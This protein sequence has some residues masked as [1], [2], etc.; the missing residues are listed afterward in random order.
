VKSAD[1][2]AAIRRR[3]PSAPQGRMVGQWTTL[4][5]L[6]G[7]DAVA[8][9]AWGKGER[10][11][12]EVKVSRS[13][14]RR[15]LLC[16]EKREPY[17]AHVH[18]LFLATPA[19]LL[20]DDE[21]AYKQP[22]DWT[23]DDYLRPACTNE[24]CWFNNARWASNRRARRFV[25]KPF[26]RRV[27]GHRARGRHDQPRQPCATTG[28]TVRD[29]RTT[30]RSRRAASSAAAPARPDRHASSGRRRRSGYRRTS[31]CSKC[32]SPATAASSE[33]RRDSNR[34]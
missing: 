17:K 34:R 26:S 13:D 32:T 8:F 7:I 15:E 1:V 9:D 25:P 11:G 20:T 33:Q 4:T 30:T 24:A 29:S 14:L 16:P 5:E 2:I 23:A 21:K 12:Y 22:A 18:R 6:W 19:G 31:A 28:A 10:I 3:H 27:E